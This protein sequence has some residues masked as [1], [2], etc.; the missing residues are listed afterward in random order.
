M[1]PSGSVGWAAVSAYMSYVSPLPVCCP[2]K[3]PP[4]QLVVHTHVASGLCWLGKLGL[5]SVVD[6]GAGIVW[7]GLLAVPTAVG[8]A[9]G[10]RTSIP[11]PKNTDSRTTKI[12]ALIS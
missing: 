11:N 4:Y 7:E 2:S 8:L 9:D 1:D 3:S 12:L 5:A 6:W 10:V